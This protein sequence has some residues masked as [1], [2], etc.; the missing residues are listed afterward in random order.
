MA[1]VLGLGE[2]QGKRDEA[3]RV[4]V[5]RS[6]GEGHA[7]DGEGSRGKACRRGRRESRC[8]RRVVGGLC[9]SA[10]P[11]EREDAT[12]RLPS[13]SLHARL[14]VERGN[15]KGARAIWPHR[16]SGVWDG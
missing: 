5:R 12:R 8:R 14:C 4:G 6:D 3:L 9:C 15:G 16:V 11:S 2:A 1:L 7:G 13:S 10:W